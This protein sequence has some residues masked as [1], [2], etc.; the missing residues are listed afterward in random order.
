M[1]AKRDYDI[2][3]FGATGFT[4]GLTA[5]YLAR[6]APA[7]A[8]WAL[9]GRNREK[10]EAVRRRLAEI[11]PACRELPLL[12]ADASAPESLRKLADSTRVIVTT[13]GPYILHGEPLVAACAAAGT[14]YVDLTGE[15]E[16]VD[17]MWLRYHEQARQSGARLVHCCGF[18]SIPHDLGAWFTVQQL[19]EG[20][21]IK[22][23][24][25]VRAGGSFSAGTY[26]SAIHAFARVREYQR[27]RKERR[28]REG[29]S[30]GR[31]VRAARGGI[32]YRKDLG[33]WAV[34]MP[35]IDPQ[36]I[37]RSAR[38]LDR[39]GPDFAYGHYVLV[40]RLA[41]VA[42]LIGGVAALFAAAQL[43]PART[44]LL[45][46]KRSGEGPTPEQR[47]KAWF[48]VRFVGEGGGR[49]VVTEVSG[50]DPGYGETSKM[51][52]ESALCLAFDELPRRAGQLTPAVAMGDALLTRLQNVGIRFTVVEQR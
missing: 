39:Y 47:E 41:S 20:V 40:K 32:R 7:A 36:I 16:F 31:G 45:A 34:P 6:H 30:N 38:M 11:N 19:P 29:T 33:A 35:T 14:D 49:R 37:Q 51:L 24:G 43:K 26:H 17:L 27:V 5:E 13:V 4:G 46:R 12:E 52:A 23:E 8:R 10:L 1:P 22:L 21:P 42:G 25:F 28:A 50:G 18:D 44:W 9:S 3:L 2:V 15:P 48:R